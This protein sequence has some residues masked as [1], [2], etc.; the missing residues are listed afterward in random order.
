MPVAEPHSPGAASGFPL[1]AIPAHA[2]VVVVGA[3]QAGLS[4]AHHLAHRGL[5]P[6]QDLVVL[7][8]SPAAGGAWQFRWESLRLGTAHRV[9]DLPGMRELG[10]SFETAD[11]GR[12][13]RDVVGEYYAEYERHFG[14]AVFRPV[15]VTSV[16]EAARASD[17]RAAPLRVDYRRGAGDG[18]TRGTVIADLLVNATGTWGA[19]IR[20]YITGIETFRGRQL[21]TPEYRSAA[22]F[23]GRR[24]VVVGG[25]TSAVGFVLEL[26]GIAASVTWVTRRPVSFAGEEPG[27][28]S[29]SMEGR[30]AAV[31][32]QNDAAREGRVLPSIISGTGLPAT[33]RNLD[34]ARRG[35]LVARPLFTGIEPG[36]VRFADG[37]FEPADAIIWA[38]GFRSELGHLDPLGLREPG[39]GVAA[40][41]GRAERDPRVFLAGYGPQASTIGANR[42][43]RLVAL[44]V[45]EV[46]AALS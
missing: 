27:E 24:V 18:A 37:S 25:G 31:A 33:A 11:Q 3:G 16:R 12:A 32:Q 14:L 46:L 13:A 45:L 40:T 6:G 34:A 10:L 8:R 1:P 2:R 15:A 42:A 4:V 28:A 9:N 20:P 41:Q 26:E 39:G 7:D 36:G 5:A 23:G 22:E 29:A 17:A 38:T 44:Q 19:P 43:G 35:V 21:S 30:L